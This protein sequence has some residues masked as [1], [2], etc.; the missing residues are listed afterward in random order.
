MANLRLPDGM[1]SERIQSRRRLLDSFDDARREIDASG[2]MSGLDAFTAR[3]LDMVLSG[4]VRQA[5]DLT[6]EDPRIR[7][8]YR[9]VEQFLTARRLVEA[10]VGCVTPSF[11]GNG[12]TGSWDTHAG[13][14]TTLRRL[15]PDLDRG[16]SSLVQDLSDR[17]LDQDVVTVMWGEFGRTPRINSGGSTG[18][19]RDHWPAVMS[20]LV[21]GGG[22]KMGQAVGASSAR[23]EYPAQRRCTVQQVFNDL[24][25]YRRSTDV[26]PRRSRTDPGIALGECQLQSSRLK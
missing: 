13:N 11:G 2:T 19:G 22:L 10:G 5:L 12:N 26:S 17:G 24:S 14:F 7:D 1:D 20:A 3:A 23:G 4:T 16:V 18:A 21:A 25:G 15:L 6:R 8:R 9:G